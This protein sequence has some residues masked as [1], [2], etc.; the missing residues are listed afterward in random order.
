MAIG[1]MLLTPETQDKLGRDGVAELAAW[2]W[3]VD[4]QTC[5][6]PLGSSPPALCVDDLATFAVASLHHDHCRAPAWSDGPLAGPSASQAQLSHRTRL[7]MLP[8][9]GGAGR[10]LMPVMVVN[11][12]MESVFLAPSP[13]GRWR[14]QHHNSFPVAGLVPPGRG[15]KLHVPVSGARARLTAA[16]VEVTLTVPPGSTYICDLAPQDEPF[17]RQITSQRGIMLAISHAVDPACA[18]LAAQF[19]QATRTPGRVLAGWVALGERRA[20]PGRR[21]RKPKEKD[22]PSRHRTPADPGPGGQAVSELLNRYHPR[23]SI[24]DGDRL[25]IEPGKV[26]ANIAFAMERVDTD[27]DT[28]VSIEEDVAPLDELLS[29]I[30]Q[31]RLGPALAVHV[32]NTAM[33]IM[34]ARYPA[35]LVRTPLPPG[36]DLRKLFPLTLTDQQHD[37]AKT[38]FNR[39]TAS[40]TDLTTDDVPELESLDWTDQMQI[41]AAL[42]YMYGSKI[43]AMKHRTGT[44]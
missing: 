15:L 6:A 31:L 39:R 8:L 4:C 21:G 17:R 28:P 27:I 36:Y 14:P 19:G 10:E 40:T 35:S 32:V 16:T 20:A 18:G 12:G 1:K 43:G 7:I 41:F 42:F 38:V 9:T 2:V 30:Q 37:T 25:I 29:M 5:G 34:S 3:P 11:P 33:R 23:A 24:S 44:E 22:T 13:D 26:L